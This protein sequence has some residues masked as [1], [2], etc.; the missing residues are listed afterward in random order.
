VINATFLNNLFAFCKKNW[1][2][3]SI[4]IKII[5]AWYAFFRQIQGSKIG[6]EFWAPFRP[7]Q[8]VSVT[9]VPR[10]L[11][12]NDTSRSPKSSFSENGDNKMQL[13]KVW[14]NQLIKIKKS[15]CPVYTLHVLRQI[16]HFCFEHHR[17][18]G[19]LPHLCTSRTEFL[20]PEVMIYSRGDEVARINSTRQSIDILN[21]Y[22]NEGMGW[23]ARHVVLLFCRNC[24]LHFASWRKGKKLIKIRWW[25]RESKNIVPDE[26][27]L[28]SS[29]TVFILQLN[30]LATKLTI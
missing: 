21:N 16:E 19:S 8:S 4:I 22:G 23:A 28:N 7:C 2:A 24:N 9:A 27:Q 13:L 5:V 26:T 3:C 29:P 20:P 12:V 10:A 15:T 11:C 18:K 17:R 1:P 30:F 25:W 14:K 6:V